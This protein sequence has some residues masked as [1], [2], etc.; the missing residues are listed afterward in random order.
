[1]VTKTVEHISD[2]TLSIFDKVISLVSGEIKINCSSDELVKQN[3]DDVKAAFLSVGFKNVDIRLKESR[4][5]FHFE[6]E[7]KEVIIGGSREFNKGDSI[8]KKNEVIIVAYTVSKQAPI[9]RTI[10]VVLLLATAAGIV[11][12]LFIKSKNK[13]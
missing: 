1:N 11:C 4:L 10:L 6:N 13:N 9:Y 8:N 3:A 12:V 5:G 7:V 2:N